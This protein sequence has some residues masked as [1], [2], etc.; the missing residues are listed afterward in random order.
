MTTSPLGALAPT[1][2][3]NSSWIGNLANKMQILATATTRLECHIKGI[4]PTDPNH[5]TGTSEDIAKALETLQEGLAKYT[6]NVLT[7]LS[8]KTGIEDL[9]FAIRLVENYLQETKGLSKSL[10]ILKQFDQT[11][12]PRAEGQMPQECAGTSGSF[13]DLYDYVPCVRQSLAKT[14]N[15]L[16]DQLNLTRDD[17]NI[18]GLVDESQRI[19]DA[20]NA[21]NL[22][23]PDL[24]VIIPRLINHLKLARDTFKHLIPSGI[25]LDEDDVIN[26]KKLAGN[27]GKIT[28]KL[29]AI[30]VANSALNV[31]RTAIA[32]SIQI[33][34]LLEVNYDALAA[35]VRSRDLEST[36]IL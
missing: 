5:Y 16:L 4:N 24:T 26:L 35:L 21:A 19:L 1:V 28:E 10:S 36:G 23:L 30:S 8:Q 34:D 6:S 20:L 15:Q 32:Q 7:S 3:S 29:Q 9:I 33:H 27:W 12:H 14:L 2:G 22:D 25:S 31:S 11:E 13:P 18:K 17:V